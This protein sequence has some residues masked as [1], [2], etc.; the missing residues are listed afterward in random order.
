MASLADVPGVRVGYAQDLGALTGCTVILFE[1]GAVGGLDLRG[2]ATG[3]RQM[4]VLRPQHLVGRI[5]AVFF[6]GGSAF[7]LDAAAGVM[8]FL[9]AKGVGFPTGQTTVPLSLIHI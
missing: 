5:D 8:T 6:A 7:G 4:D 3:T 2:S 9:E 1:G